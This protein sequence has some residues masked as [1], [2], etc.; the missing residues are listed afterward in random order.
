MTSKREFLLLADD[1]QTAKHDLSGW[2]V[3]EKLDGHRCFYDGGVSRG[4][5]ASQVP[6]SNTT[7]DARY[8]TPPIATGLWSRYGK[9][10]TPPDWWI[11]DLPKD[12]S[13]DGELYLGPGKFE[14]TS[15]IVKTI[16]PDERWR[17]VTLMVIDAPSWLSVLMTGQINN[18]NWKA[19]LDESMIKWV[20]ARREAL[21]WVATGSTIE[22]QG[23]GLPD[24]CFATLKNLHLAQ[25]A[26]HEGPDPI[27][28]LPI[29]QVKLPRHPDDAREEVE[30]R[31]M[32]V[33]AAGGEG[34]V[35][36][37]PAGAWLPKRVSWLL[38]AKRLQD[39]E[40]TVTG[41]T[42]GR[43][44]ALGSRHLGRMGALVLD[45]RGKRLELSGFTDA[46]RAVTQVRK[47]DSDHAL[48]WIETSITG[49][50]AGEK[51]LVPVQSLANEG[52][53]ASDDWW[54]VDFPK[55]SKVTFQYR[56]LSAD[57]IAKEARFYRKHG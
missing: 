57:G 38:K 32:E 55:G 50:A 45:F 31:L 44:T 49:G 27:P 53:D 23:F 18:A 4:V 46:E 37:N 43:R 28:W 25:A 3:S 33:T 36:R 34:L 20:Q 42:W 26:N 1:W 51:R 6:Y 16:T 30:R 14:E 5:P 41:W 21:G 17:D 12:I 8:K 22:F 40:G 56:E 35:L 39:A 11:D 13:L 48:D 24:E 2:Y 19:W 15:S 47:D 29:T 9:V 10:I 7:K 54:P 52:K